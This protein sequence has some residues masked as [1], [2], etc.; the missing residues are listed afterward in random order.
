MNTTPR[1]KVELAPVFGRHPAT[2]ARY[3]DEL[4]A[5]KLIGRSGRGGGKASHTLDYFEVSRIFISQ[6]SPVPKGAAAVV[7]AVCGLCLNGD[8]QPGT[9]TF[10][11]EFAG[12]L[13]TLVRAIRAGQDV[14]KQ[15]LPSW[16]LTICLDPPLAWETWPGDD[17]REHK[18]FYREPFSQPQPL[19]ALQR[20]TVFTNAALVAAAK[21]C[22]DLDPSTVLL[23]P[24]TPGGGAY[25]D[26]ES[27][28][29]GIGNGNEN[30][31]GTPA[32][33]APSDRSSSLD[34]RQ[35]TEG[36]SL[37][38]QARGRI[39]TRLLGRFDPILAKREGQER[40]P[41]RQG[42]M[43]GGG[44]SQKGTLHLQRPP[45]DPQ[46]HSASQGAD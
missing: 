26:S 32:P 7:K 42:D 28:P 4:H 41:C 38:G 34:P 16:T 45:H 46:S 36:L 11:T 18:R 44:Q 6:V 10:E 33:S 35:G 27:A 40:S 24:P 13:A 3:L 5:A 8:P 12:T 37:Q 17:G 19:P 30:A 23:L 1:A 25:T 2:V 39:A 21:F 15:L 31:E 43:L 29:E 20:L 14:E 9:P 22:A